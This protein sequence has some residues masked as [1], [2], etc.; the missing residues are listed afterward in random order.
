MGNVGIDIKR[1]IL[2]PMRDGV[3]LSTDVYLPEIKDSFP[4]LLMRT[5][6]DK[7]QRHFIDWIP[8]FIE[9]GYAVVIQDCRG[10]YLSLIH[11]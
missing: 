3:N 6:Y 1:D 7:T 9:R 11:I 10:K 8:R 4:V 2:V 5:I